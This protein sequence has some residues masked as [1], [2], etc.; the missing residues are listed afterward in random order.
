MSGLHT[1]Q[2]EA[3]AWRRQVRMAWAVIAIIA[4]TLGLALVGVL[5]LATHGAWG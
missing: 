1:Y 5:A 2:I 4:T 3:R